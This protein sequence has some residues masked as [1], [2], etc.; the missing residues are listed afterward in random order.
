MHQSMT[1]AC[2]HTQSTCIAVCLLMAAMC[3]FKHITSGGT[4]G[5]ISMCH[6]EM[7]RSLCHVHD[8]IV[9]LVRASLVACHM[10]RDSDE[11]TL[12]HVTPDCKLKHRGSGVFL[13]EAIA[14][15]A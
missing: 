15:A 3:K 4:S 7:Q 11:A 12:K 10:H 1:H 6:D 13:H 9:P 8:K 14:Q 2:A 5:I